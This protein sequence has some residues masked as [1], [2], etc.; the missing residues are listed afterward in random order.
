MKTSILFLA[1]SLSAC[2]FN[3]LM[4]AQ[5]NQGPHHEGFLSSLNLGIRYSSQYVNRGVVFYPGFQIDPVVAAFFFDDR[6]EFLGDSVGYR[7]FIAGNWLRLRSKLVSITDQ[8]LFPSRDSLKSGYPHRPSTDEW[9]SSVEF[10]LPA[11]DQTYHAE[12]DLTYSK[13]ISKHFGNYFE[14][15][16]KVKLFD[17]TIPNF[18]I[19][20]EPNFLSTLGF[21][22]AAHNVYFYGPSANASGFNH[23]DLGLWLAF[24]KEADRYYPIIQFK[25]FQTLGKFKDAEYAFSK[26]EGWLLS[27][28]AT[29]GVL[30]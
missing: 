22:D 5:T 14:L 1:L 2:P 27:F 13:D 20:I 17:F 26:S 19:K 15:Q 30:E 11:Y 18:G 21:G 10:F 6:L 4:A 7:D 23:L 28:I 8:P 9:S 25:H 12:I 29:L 3:F 16:S 24:P